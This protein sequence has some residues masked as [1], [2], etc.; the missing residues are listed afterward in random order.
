MVNT[1]QMTDEERESYILRIRSAV[2]RAVKET[3]LPREA[4]Y[5]D[6]DNCS[7]ASIDEI[8]EAMAQEDKQK[9]T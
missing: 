3:G 6:L 7:N 5:V 8:I 4:I 9:A 1:D 2:D